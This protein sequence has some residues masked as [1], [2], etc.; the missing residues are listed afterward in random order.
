MERTKSK[1]TKKQ[2]DIV[3]FG[4]G[5]RR[6]NMNW[7]SDRFSGD[8]NSVYE[9]VVPNLERR[10]RETESDYI[11]SEIE[12]Y[13]RIYPCPVCLG[14][15]LKPE[16]LAIT[17]ADKN[18]HEVSSMTVEESA[19]FFAL[20]GSVKAGERIKLSITE[21]KIASAVLKEIKNR[22]SFLEQFEKRVG[23]SPSLH[24]SGRGPDRDL[25][26]YRGV[27]QPHPSPLLVSPAR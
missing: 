13:M 16:V 14:K 19:K 9:G 21:E 2:L 23:S 10:Y 7:E 3:L 15:R 26:L 22:L 27:L 12:R 17:V 11:R 4:S 8:F 24:H 6:Y 5:E 18:I 20:F 25:R 1:L